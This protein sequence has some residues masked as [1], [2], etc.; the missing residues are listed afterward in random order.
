M[1]MLSLQKKYT[2]AQVIEFYLKEQNS[3]EKSMDFD[4]VDLFSEQALTTIE[5]DSFCYLDEPLN[6]DLIDEDE[7]PEGYSDF[8]LKN[9]LEMLCSGEILG[10]VICNTLHQ[11]ENASIQDM[12]DNLNFYIKNDTFKTFD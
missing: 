8:V 12:I 3:S 10:S 7:N 9:N 5:K 11:N 6:D 1:K 4:Y 2:I